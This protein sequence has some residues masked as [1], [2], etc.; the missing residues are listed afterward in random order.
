MDDC[1]Q[2]SKQPVTTFHCLENPRTESPEELWCWSVSPEAAPDTPNYIELTY[3]AI[4][5]LA[6]SPASMLT[7]LNRLGGDTGIGRL[8]IFENRFVGMKGATARV[9]TVDG[10]R[11]VDGTVNGENA[12]GFPYDIVVFG[13]RQFPSTSCPSA[14]GWLSK[15]VWEIWSR[16]QTCWYSLLVVND[17]WASLGV[18]ASVL[19]FVGGASMLIFLLSRSTL[20]ALVAWEESVVHT[21]H[22]PSWKAGLSS[23]RSRRGI[24]SLERCAATPQHSKRSITTSR[25]RAKHYLSKRLGHKPVRF[26]RQRRRDRRG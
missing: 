15:R 22:W 12:N 1:S 16:G 23:R 20:Q 21:S 8:D 4:D 17:I 7:E 25:L 6:M 3:E 26:H 2:D 14:L 5:G 18:A 11:V 9:V 24:C 19:L 13:T 10:A